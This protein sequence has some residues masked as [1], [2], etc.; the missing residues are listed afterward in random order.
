MVRS[1]SENV[2]ANSVHISAVH[3]LDVVT[4]CS[5]D[6]EKG[7]RHCTFRRLFRDIVW[8]HVAHGVVFGKFIQR[9]R[10][11]SGD[12]CDAGVIFYANVSVPTKT[13]VRYEVHAQRTV[14]HFRNKHRD[15]DDC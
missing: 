5:V 6:L 9:R 11:E 7:A 1:A 8:V 3:V 10:G 13:D 15:V 14:S 12:R 2:L 4:L